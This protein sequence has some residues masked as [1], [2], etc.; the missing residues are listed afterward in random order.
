MSEFGG[1]GRKIPD[2]QRVRG[3]SG[4]PTF[5]QEWATYYYRYRGM[6][7]CMGSKVCRD[8]LALMPGNG[9]SGFPG[10]YGPILLWRRCR[11]RFIAG[12]CATNRLLWS[13]YRGLVGGYSVAPTLN[14]SRSCSASTNLLSPHTNPAHP[15]LTKNLSGYRAFRTVPSAM[16]ATRLDGTAIAK[17][18]RERLGAEIA[19]KQQ[20]NPRYKPTLKIIQGQCC[21]LQR[22]G[23]QCFLISG[24]SRV[25]VLKQI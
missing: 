13:D 11:R 23:N 14:V 3:K 17:G 9:A 4:Q 16:A 25:P 6:L 1:V 7:T 18:I 5:A 8:G 12:S 2:S 22:R 10:R 15:T 20:L 19:E 24:L 21:S